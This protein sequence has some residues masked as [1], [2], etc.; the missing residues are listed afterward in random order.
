VPE[1]HTASLLRFEQK[2]PAKHRPYR[3]K[4][5]NFQQLCAVDISF[6]FEGRA[7]LG[8]NHSCSTQKFY[9]VPALDPKHIEGFALSVNQF[10]ATVAQKDVCRYEW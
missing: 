1:D 4:S 8:R 6:R 7:T 5:V 9:L 2:N 10:I 3:W